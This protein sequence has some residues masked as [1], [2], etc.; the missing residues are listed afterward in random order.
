MTHLYLNKLFYVSLNILISSLLYLIRL[1]V[2]HSICIVLPPHQCL[3]HL[4]FPRVLG[5]SIC[6]LIELKV[7]CSARLAPKQTETRL[8]SSGRMTTSC[9]AQHTLAT[10]CQL[11]LAHVAVVV[12]GRGEFASCVLPTGGHKSTPSAAC[13][14]QC[15]TVT[16]RRRHTAPRLALITL[17]VLCWL[18]ELQQRLC[19]CLRLRAYSCVV[20]VGV[21]YFFC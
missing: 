1:A 18:S 12:A 19:L 8:F 13:G 20:L 17:C 14:F 9:L 6:L 2:T 4:F 3:L 7:S 11:M 21:S 10:C 16:T 5:T 15:T